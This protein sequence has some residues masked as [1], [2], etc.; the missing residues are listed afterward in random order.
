MTTLKLT[1]LKTHM[2]AGQWAHAGD[3]ADVE[4]S[5][6]NELVRTGLARRTGSTPAASR[7][8]VAPELKAA[9][10][11][12][13][14]KMPNPDNKAAAFESGAPIFATLPAPIENSKAPALDATAIN[15]EKAETSAADT[16][17]AAEKT[18][19]AK[20]K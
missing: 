3:T 16:A 20:G 13:N 9:R 4:E 18:T 2:A 1:I 6:A 15:A 19:E 5:R 12:S 14:K 8:P 17:A 10:P 11:L 7:A